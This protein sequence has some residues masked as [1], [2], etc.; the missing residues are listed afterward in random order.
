MSLRRDWGAVAGKAAAA[1]GCRACSVPGPL[2][3]AHT[4]GRSRDRRVGKLAHVDPESI[5][6]LCGPFPA[7]CHGAYDTGRLDLYPK[8]SVQ[9]LSAAV[10]LAGGPGHALRCLSAPLWRSEQ[11]GDPTAGPELDRRLERLQQ[12]Q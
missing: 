1:Q 6:L 5:V 10:K 2:E 4:V 11:R 12:L 3:R 8:L 7:G 9:E